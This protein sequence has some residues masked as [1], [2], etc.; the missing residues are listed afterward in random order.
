MQSAV[1]APSTFENNIKC[2]QNSALAFHA[3]HCTYLFYVLR[4]F[5]LLRELTDNTIFLWVKQSYCDTIDL[6][7]IAQE[8]RTLK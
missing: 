8:K 2:V 6:L 4:S 5:V 3:H 1:K 7:I